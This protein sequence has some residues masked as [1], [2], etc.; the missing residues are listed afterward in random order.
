M[1]PNQKRWLSSYPEGIPDILHTP[2][3]TVLDAFRSRAASH[4]NSTC[5]I[6]FDEVL[7]YGD[8]E[9]ASDALCATLLEYSVEGR[10][11]IMLQNDPQFFVAQLAAWKAGCAM[12]SVNPMLRE[13][14]LEYIL[15]D[16]GASALVILESLYHSTA[17]AVLSRTDI[18]L[19]VTTT[20]EDAAEM[21]RATGSTPGR[22]RNA[23]G[24]QIDMALALATWTGELS[25]PIVPRREDLAC[26]GYTSGTSGKPKGVMN[27]HGNLRYSAEV[28][29]QWMDIHDSD[30]FLCGAPLFHVTGLV[31]GLALGCISGM[32]IVLFH[33][34]SPE[35]CLRLA[36][37]WKCSFTVMAL[38][39]F[40][41]LLD[42]P[43]LRTTNLNNLSK[44]YSG[45]SPVL[46]GTAYDWEDTTGHKMRN[47]YG[48]TETTG[49][50]HAVPRD[51]ETRVDPQSGALSVGVPLP[52]ADVLIVDPE[53]QQS[54][55]P[56]YAGE[57]WIKGPM[58]A[59]GYWNRPDD[60]SFV[61]G[62]LRTGDVGLMDDSGWFYIVDRLKDMI[63][64]SGYKVWPREVEDT[65]CLHPAVREAAVVGV[66][67][68]YRGE[69]VHA[70]VTVTPGSDVDA[71]E[72]LE[73][74]RNNLAA[75]KYPRH[76]EIVADLPKT[77][78]GKI[79]RREL[80]DRS[81]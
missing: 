28:Y 23:N 8:I 57:I 29:R 14:E 22:D 34:F 79:L 77:T 59:A 6:Y 31:A 39:A 37:T 12:V 47:V 78:S 67:D 30:V 52:G 75:Y 16:S 38:T 9:K 69:T 10:V 51:L 55:G 66:P 27:T 3:E 71:S 11:A 5:L 56:G 64:V 73:Y 42:S 62:Y 61:D 49:P 17:S 46:S 48:L 32:P 7:T 1:T 53:T 68:S 26:L 72:L 45:G 24:R 35:D 36:E 40:R 4:G 41:S 15:S 2:N 65:L 25:P 63:N 81:K 70:F 18:R 50:S 43:D 33:R 20:H 74:C 54:L 44:V 58:V 13:K 80:R 60:A 76:I 19:V 21:I